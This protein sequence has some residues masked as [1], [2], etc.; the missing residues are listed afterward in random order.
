MRTLVGALVLCLTSLV[1]TAQPSIQETLLLIRPAVV[2]V[3]TEVGSHV[4][5]DCGSGRK[6]DVT[7]QP[8]RET[9]TGWFVAA[10]GSVVTSASTVDAAVRSPGWLRDQQLERAVRSACLPTF[11]SAVGAELS[12]DPQLVEE[13]TRALV[14]AARRTARVTLEPSVTIVLANGTRLPATI[15]KPALAEAGAPA[16]QDL[17][18][19]RVVIPNAPVLPL[20]DS[21]RLKLGDPIRVVAYPA[22]VLG[23]ELLDRSAPPEPSVTTGAVSGFR[24]D[25]TGRAL[26]QTDAPAWGSSGGPAVDA[27]GRVVGMLAFTGTPDADTSE[28]AQ[29]F[30]FLVPVAD[31]RD[32]LAGT[33]VEVRTPSRF[34]TAWRAGLEAFFAGRHSDATRHFTEVERLLPGLPDVA[35]VMAENERL[36]ETT[37]S[38]RRIW[39]TGGVIAGLTGAIA[40]AITAKIRRARNRFRIRPAAVA[41]LLESEAP[42]L[43]IDARD[44]ATYARSPVRLPRAVHISPDDLETGVTSLAIEPDRP[45][46]AYCS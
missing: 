41:A 34:N 21:T 17:A 9:G 14:S 2:L 39:F 20:G 8:F 1:A 35:R 6:I 45:V 43:I 22:V 15:A 40:V 26:I 3:V 38:T 12:Q 42:P 32:F 28:I 23:H 16:V 7:P 30:N 13:T 24:Q 19:L 36:R 37:T 5:L 33:A 11:P 27:Q 4:R 31:V 46:V 25:R 10:D 29:G 18:L 44:D